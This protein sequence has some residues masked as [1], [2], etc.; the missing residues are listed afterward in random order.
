MQDIMDC[1]YE[2]ICEHRLAFYLNADPNYLSAGRA[3]ERAERWLE[4]NLPPEARAQLECLTG[5]SLNQ[6]ELLQR[7]LFRCGLS[8]GLELGALG[9]V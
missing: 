1:L 3:V 6:A 9:R 4:A 7:A 2:Y 5:G 8:L